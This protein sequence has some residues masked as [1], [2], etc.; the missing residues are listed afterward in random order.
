MTQKA[1][2]NRIPGISFVSNKRRLA[3]IFERMS[4]HYDADF[5]FAPKSF[6]LP[7]DLQRLKRHFGKKP[8]KHFMI[9]K[10]QDGSEGC[11]IFLV[12]SMKDIPKYA[13]Q[14]EYVVQD[15]LAHPL[16]LDKK[17]FDLRV[18]VL[19][20]DLAPMTAFIADEAMVRF[21]TE[22]YE[23]PTNENKHVLLSHLTNFSLNKLSDKYV[24]GDDLEMQS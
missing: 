6:V 18:Y 24:N 4:R 12:Q 19:V 22:N 9:A 20:T 13:I 1:I 7:D 23:E 3:Q 15:Y 16:L 5:N 21:C 10:P 11:G 2:Y 17:K 14:Q 8:D